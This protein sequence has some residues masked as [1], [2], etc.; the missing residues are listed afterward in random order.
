M[1]WRL[2]VFS[3][4]TKQENWMRPFSQTQNSYIRC[5]TALQWVYSTFNAYLH[6]SSNFS[7]GFP[8]AWTSRNS[9]PTK[10][11]SVRSHEGQN[12][13]GP[14]RQLHVPGE[15]EF[16][17]IVKKLSVEISSA[18]SGYSRVVFK[19]ELQHSRNHFYLLLLLIYQ[20]KLFS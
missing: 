19:D 3:T 5:S 9:Q 15:K 17:W 13:T 16:D 7:Q 12:L 6:E 20:T 10:G 8:K 18:A 11:F 14:L 4:M 2:S 1:D